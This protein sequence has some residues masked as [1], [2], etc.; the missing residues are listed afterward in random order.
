MGANEKKTIDKTIK[1]DKTIQMIFIRCF[2]RILNF[3]VYPV[4]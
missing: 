1:K 4:K 3:I 2:L